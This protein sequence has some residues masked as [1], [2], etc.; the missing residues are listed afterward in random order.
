MSQSNML[1]SD[2]L[3]I[4][5][6]SVS[7]G[8]DTRPV[9]PDSKKPQTFFG[10]ENQP[11][12]PLSQEPNPAANP[13][14]PIVPGIIS[15]K[16]PSSRPTYK[17]SKQP[18]TFLEEKKRKNQKQNVRHPPIIYLL[19]N[20]LLRIMEHLLKMRP[21]HGNYLNQQQNLNLK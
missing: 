9:Y 21:R 7:G 17:S 5:S 19:K 12:Y 18:K 15:D 14:S 2:I 1:K 4:L 13:M 16:D 11:F 10:G 3:K 20:I 8:A 6:K